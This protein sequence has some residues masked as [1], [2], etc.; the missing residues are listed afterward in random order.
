[1][2]RFDEKSGNFYCTE[3]GR[4]ASHFYIRYSSVETYNEMLR[5]HMNDSE[6]ITM[7]AHS[8]EFENIAVRE[9]E[10]QELETLVRTSC[11]LEVRGGPGDKY[12]KISILI[13]V[14]ISRGSLDSFSL[15]ADAAYISASLARIMSGLFEICLRRGWSE[16]SSLLLGYCK[17]VDRQIWPHQHPLRQ[18][19][20]DI[21]QDI[22]RRLEDRDADL[23]HLHELD[24]KDIGALIHYFPGGKDSENDHIYHSEL[25]IL[26]KKM[27]RGGPQKINFTVPLFE[28]HPAQYYIR[29]V[30]DSWLQSEAIHAISFL[31]LTLPE[32]GLMI[33]DEIHLLGADRGPILEVIVSRMRYISSQTERAVRFVGLSTA[34]ANARD[35]A[36]WL[37]V[38][39]MGLFNFKPSVRPV[40]LEVHIQVRVTISCSYSWS[41]LMFSI[42]ANV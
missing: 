5:R 36:D 41:L 39:D 16:M 33:L 30:S 22:L 24:E 20:K 31:N 11:P 17:A 14:F 10:Q 4:I 32:V 18:F 7:V 12:G 21:S 25:F 23:D 34:L 26:T 19:D 15:V 40:P 1:M 6:I 9:E 38:S 29:A 2:M 27:A 3:L 28:P 42:M 8:S 37:G 13:Q 35:L